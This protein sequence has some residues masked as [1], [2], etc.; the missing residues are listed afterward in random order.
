M[1]FT[2]FIFYKIEYILRATSPIHVAMS[3][4]ADPAFRCLNAELFIFI[5]KIKIISSWGFL[6]S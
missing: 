5:S 3:F 6:L 2:L 4:Y 1:L